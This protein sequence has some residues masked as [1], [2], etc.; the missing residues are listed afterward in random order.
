MVT[1]C[2]DGTVEIAERRFDLLPPP[3]GPRSPAW[4]S[5]EPN[6]AETV[7]TSRAC[8]DAQVATVEQVLAWRGDLEAAFHGCTH[9]APTGAAPMPC[10]THDE[11]EAWCRSR[12]GRLPSIEEWEALARQGDPPDG[13][14]A[15]RFEWTANPFPPRVFH[16]RSTNIPGEFVMRERLLSPGQA[17]TAA[18]RYSWHRQVASHR[19]HSLFVRCAFEPVAPRD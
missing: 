16:L 9:P 7:E 1:T 19:V 10:L 2:P 12:N 6:R 17:S 13:A 14:H 8:F 3:A 4:I 15:G 5:L 18:P 11:A